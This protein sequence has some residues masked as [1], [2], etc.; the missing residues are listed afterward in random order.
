MVT[1]YEMEHSLHPVPRDQ[2]DTH[3]PNQP[4]ICGLLNALSFCKKPEVR[5]SQFY[6]CTG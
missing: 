2:S 6:F 1:F 3:P 5:F 4:T